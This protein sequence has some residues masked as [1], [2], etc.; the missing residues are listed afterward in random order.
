MIRGLSGLTRHSDLFI[1]AEID[2]YGHYFRKVREPAI[3]FN[4]RAVK[5]ARGG[6]GKV[7]AIKKNKYIFKTFLKEDV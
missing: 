1:V 2:S 4:G 5:R 3:F 7:P 6:G